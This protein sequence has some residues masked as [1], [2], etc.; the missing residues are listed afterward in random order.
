MAAK[1]MATAAFAEDP[2]LVVLMSPSRPGLETSGGRS[3]P[4]LGSLRG[5]GRAGEGGGGST[6]ALS[7]NV[8]LGLKQK[9]P[10]LEGE[11]PRAGREPQRSGEIL[12]LRQRDRDRL[13]AVQEIATCRV[14]VTRGAEMLGLSRRQAQRLVT[15]YREE[16]DAA[17]VHKG[18]ARTDP[19]S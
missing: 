4:G 9:C 5:P 1:G 6:V 18:P 7:R 11:G 10:T 13:V 12:K 8:S 14:R 19:R 16:G 3:T 17:V 2:C 15:A